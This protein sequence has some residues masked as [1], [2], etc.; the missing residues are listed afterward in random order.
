MQY[1]G[2]NDAVGQGLLHDGVLAD[3]SQAFCADRTAS[4]W[5]VYTDEGDDLHANAAVLRS[6]FG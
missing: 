6:A 5:Q 3:S 1:R 2:A 4:F